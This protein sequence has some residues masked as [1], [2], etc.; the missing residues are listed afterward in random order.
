MNRK[1]HK[2]S[3]IFVVCGKKIMLKNITISVHKINV[4]DLFE[5]I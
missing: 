5:N 4:N 2:Y 1:A 3:A